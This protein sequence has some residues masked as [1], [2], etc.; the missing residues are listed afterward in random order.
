MQYLPKIHK[1]VQTWELLGF[2]PFPFPLFY[3]IFNKIYSLRH[4]RSLQEILNPVATAVVID[5]D[6]PPTYTLAL[7]FRVEVPF[8][9]PSDPM[10]MIN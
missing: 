6:F 8:P 1:G 2:S 7:L 10:S 3:F 4:W 5:C 9:N